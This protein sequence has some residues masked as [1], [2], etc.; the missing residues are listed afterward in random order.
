[1]KKGVIKAFATACAISLVLGSAAACSGGGDGQPAGK[2]GSAASASPAEPVT[3]SVIMPDGGRVFKEDNPVIAELEKQTNTKLEYT[4]VPPSEFLSKYGVMVASGSVPDI[5]RLN[6]FD[7]FQ[8]VNQ[9]IYLDI[10][11]LVE[12]DAPNLKK[13]I[14]PESWDLV[15]YQG[16]NYAVPYVNSSGKYVHVVRQDWLDNLGLKVPETLDEFTEMLR[17]FTFSDPDKNGKNDTYGFAGTDAGGSIYTDEFM[18]VF[19]AFGMQ[20]LQY[21]LKD[22][23]VYS[24]SISQEYKAAVEYIAQLYSEKLIDPEIFL[25]K[26]DQALQKLVQS[27]S[28]SFCAWWSIAPQVLVSQLKMK[29]INP[30]AEWSVVYPLKGKDGLYGMRD[31]G[32]INGTTSISAKCENPEAAIKF[33]DYIASDE[34]KLLVTQGIQGVHYTE[35]YAPTEEGK[36][37]KDQKWL[38]VFSQIVGN[39]EANRIAYGKTNPEYV[40]F[41]VS[42]E[43]AKL[44]SNLFYGVTTNDYQTLL[45]DVKK[46][47]EEWF[48]KFVTGAEPISKFDEYVSQWKAKGGQQISESLLAEY[49]KRNA[50]SYTLGD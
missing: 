48:I 18:S 40:D 21:Y 15:K 47:E 9:G 30:D 24:S 28:G 2:A 34:G 5:S 6:G 36:A 7:Y 46:L 23:K 17:K 44:I 25:S 41:I 31:N 42:G 49:N 26:K 10:G 16:K 22:G 35:P 20:P 39:P 50:T 38:D 1:M 29:E 13:S 37:A 12:K 11:D 4:L 45:P 43:D 33:I 8:F 14:K 27:K 3:L 19:G 32:S